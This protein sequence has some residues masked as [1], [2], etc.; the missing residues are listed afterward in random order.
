LGSIIAVALASAILASN[1]GDGQ[2]R[3]MIRLSLAWYAAALGLMMF[4]RPADWPAQTRLGRAARWCWTWG[5]ACFVVH[6][7]LAFHYF[8]HWSHTQAFEHTR[9]V[10]GVGEG[11]YVSYLFTCL[12]VADASFWWLAPR[13]YAAR[14]VWLDRLLH[15][16]MLFMVFNGT[17]VFET[18]PIRWVSLVVLAVLGVMWMLSR[19]TVSSPSEIR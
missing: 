14:S 10:S 8:H 13:R 1:F 15:G 19:G 12:W 5:A 6:V 4:M 18:G 17:V 9:A 2:T 11:L 7:L 16:F 3:N